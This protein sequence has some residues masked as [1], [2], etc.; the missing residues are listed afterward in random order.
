MEFIPMVKY[1]NQ[2]NPS[3]TSGMDFYL[4]TGLDLQFLLHAVCN[5]MQPAVLDMVKNQPFDGFTPIFP[6]LLGVKT[7]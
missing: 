6:D 1:M 2:L 7:P 3:L 4:K 5:R